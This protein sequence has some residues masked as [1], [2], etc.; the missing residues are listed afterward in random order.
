MKRFLYYC[1]IFGFLMFLSY[2]V[3]ASTVLYFDLEQL[4]I[5]SEYIVFGKA[6][7]SQSF[8]D[9]KHQKIFTK[10]FIELSETLK[11]F[12]QSSEYTIEPGN[13]KKVISIITLGGEIP[14]LGMHVPGEPNFTKDEETILFLIRHPL[15][16]KSFR[17]LGMSQGKWNIFIHPQTLE[18]FVYPSTKNLNLVNNP[19]IQNI[20]LTHFPIRL[21][22]L[23]EDLLQR[24]SLPSKQIIKS[25]MSLKNKNK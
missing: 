9:E 19:Q 7:S 3:F 18:K 21:S 12:E 5:Q 24:F 2:Q 8:W 14:K 10:H 4:K 1:V 11:D 22:L 15:F 13:A 20:E 23:R 6:Q 17:V 16:K 25:D